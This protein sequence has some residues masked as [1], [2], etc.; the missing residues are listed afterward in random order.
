[1][2]KGPAWKVRGL[3]ISKGVACAAS[4]TKHNRHPNADN[5]EIRVIERRCL[6]RGHCFL[7]A[8]RLNI[9]SSRSIAGDGVDGP[10]QRIHWRCRVIEC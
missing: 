10:P 2:P 7:T 3:G 4:L 5:A 1:M 8:T 9:F 6:I